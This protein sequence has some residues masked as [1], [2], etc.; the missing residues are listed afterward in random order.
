MARKLPPAKVVFACVTNAGRSQM[1][2][3][4]FNK[5]ANP[6]RARA[7]SAGTHPGPAVHPEVVAVMREMHIDLSGIRPQYLTTDLTNDA[8]IVITMGCGDQCPLVAGVERDEWPLDDPGEKPLEAVRQIRDEIASRVA[9][10]IEER[11][12]K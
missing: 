5:M 3:A 7:V 4:I 9:A 1:A 2:Q 6:R 11:R 12:W 8:H 10:L